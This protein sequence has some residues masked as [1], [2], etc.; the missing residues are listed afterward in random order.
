MKHFITKLYVVSLMLALPLVA[1]AQ[2]KVSGKLVDSSTNE[3]LIGAAI[4]LESDKGVGITTSLD[5]TFALNLESGKQ[6]LVF[7]YLGYV[8][9]TKSINVDGDV[10]LGTILMESNAV[11]LNEVRVMA[12]VVTDRST[13]VAVST[14]PA[15]VITEKLGT[16]EYPELLKTT[17]SIYT[18]K[19]GGGFGDATVY[20]R[21]FDSNNVGVLINGIPVNDMENGKVYWS[22]WAGLS[23]VS[24]TMQVQRG[25][26]ASKLGLSSV[27]GTINILTKSTEAKK[28]GV[29]KTFV[30][31]SGYR[32]Q[33]VSFSTGLMENGWAVTMLG[34]HTYGDGYVNG[35]DFD[36]WNYFANI[37]KKINDQHTLAFTIVGAPQWHNQRGTKL[38][39]E[40]FKNHKDGIRHNSNYGIRNGQV[41]GGAYGYN[42]YH[43]PQAQ[44]NHYWS[45]NESTSLTSSFYAS[46]GTGGGRRS[47]GNFGRTPDGLIDFDSAMEEN[48]QSVV[49][50]SQNIIGNSV[51]NHQWFGL[52]STLT[53]EVNSITFTF[54]LD[55]RYYNGEHYREID[56]LL[57]G[58]FYTDGSNINRDQYTKLTEGDKYSYHN[59]GNVGYTGLFGQAEYVSGNF[60]SFL[61]A[62]ISRKSYRRIDYFKY[63][64]DD[65]KTDWEHFFPWNVKAG[66]SYKITENH[67]ILAN[68][69]YIKRT[70]YF[71]NVFL[72]YSNEVNENV[73]Y[74]QIITAEIGYMYSSSNF[75]AKI[76]AYRTNW[77]DKGLLLSYIYRIENPDNPDEPLLEEDRTANVA[78]LNQLHQGIEVEATYKPNEKLSLKGMFSIGDWIYQDDVNFKVFNDQQ[79]LQAELDAYI[80]DV[81]VGNSAQMTGSLSLDYKIFPDFKVGVDYIFYGKH[82]ADFDPESRKKV[83]DSGVDSWEL[84]EVGLVDLNFNYKFKLAGLDAA[85][86]GNVNNLFNTEYISKADDGTS[87][88]DL[89][90][91]VYYGFGTTWSSGLRIK[92]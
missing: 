61:S 31:N 84:P 13:P 16:Q 4:Y 57:G 14:L 27:G 79:E 90:S 38:T 51:N 53:K 88:D 87:H 18:S 86:Y 22:N 81:H 92:F 33:L 30:G 20:V 55:A 7:T 71:N 63:T 44:L 10:N 32:K 85:I 3:P 82:Y 11:G 1:I 75:N 49:E 26:G 58:K 67:S 9:Q 48:Q 12:S 70:P 59:D 6:T 68:G 54:G 36:A 64:S 23:D 73:K 60:T 25:L 66:I 52:L 19:E 76:N 72:N 28:G 15:E 78:G 80:K 5:G 69:G 17:P 77:R 74:E 91:E 35:T 29:I 40:E 47:A 83:T 41:Y 37:A 50:G 43:K 56:D 8:E 34:A 21:G 24:R 46:I 39:I 45:M 62:A 42:F 89:T 2:G 65:Q